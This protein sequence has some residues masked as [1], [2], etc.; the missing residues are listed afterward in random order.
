MILHSIEKEN[1]S[2]C[3]SK[4]VI[5]RL[6]SLIKNNQREIA[7]LNPPRNDLLIQLVEELQPKFINFLSDL[8][9]ANFN[10]Q[11]IVKLKTRLFHADTEEIA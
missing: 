6:L 5:G 11:M 1:T 9:D 4:K 8:S 2:V 7:I 3:M 10:D